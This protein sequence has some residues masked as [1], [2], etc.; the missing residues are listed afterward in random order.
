MPKSTKNN[1]LRIRFGAGGA[2]VALLVLAGCAVSQASTKLAAS[3]DS[4]VVTEP[5][6]DAERSGGHIAVGDSVYGKYLAARHAEMQSEFARA[7][8]LLLGVLKSEPDNANLLRRTHLLLASE[9]RIEEAV[10]LAERL[11]AMDGA[12]PFADITLALRDT[13][14]GNFEAA[15]KRLDAI[16]LT[17]TNQL[18]VPMLRAWALFGAGRT[19]EAL[20]TLEPLGEVNGFALMEG[21][22]SGLIADLAGQADETEEA[23]DRAHSNGAIPLRLALAQASFLSREGRW[24]D[25]EA[26]LESFRV[27]QADDF[28]L[29]PGA[30]AL[31]NRQTVDRIVTGAADGMAEALVSVA[32]ALNRNGGD[33]GSLIYT[34]MAMALRPG[35]PMTQTLLAD[36]LANQNRWEAAIAVLRE[37]EP[38]SPYSWFA[39]RSMAQMLEA[40]GKFEEAVALLEQMV[41]ERT[42]RVEAAQTL[43]DFLRLNDQ[44]DEAVVAYDVAVDRVATIDQRHWRLLYTRGIALERAKNW[45]RAEKDFLQALELQPQQPLVL[46]YL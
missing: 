32:R 24:E 44:F 9:G 26:A 10:E 2:V 30:D 12:D 15:E 25:A 19:D 29:R 22:H 3:D 27:Q 45:P 39:R 16:E 13:K 8:D 43:G 4:I 11:Q 7:A 35:D 17:G 20:E 5:G 37:I 34:R 38:A 42:D 46:N 40:T 41:S 36:V 33:I 14:E 23:F 31:A 21:L 18:L 1:G 6:R 28:L